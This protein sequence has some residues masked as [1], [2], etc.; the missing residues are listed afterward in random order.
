M[1]FPM[2]LFLSTLERG[3]ITELEEQAQQSSIQ[4]T[5]DIKTKFPLAWNE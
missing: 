1:S 2:C 3:K 4:M 5:V